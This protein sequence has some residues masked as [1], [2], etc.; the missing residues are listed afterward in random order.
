MAAKHLSL[1]SCVRKSGSEGRDGSVM[2]SGTFNGWATSGTRMSLGTHQAHGATYASWGG[3]G[4]GANAPAPTTPWELRGN[5]QLV[6]DV[7]PARW[8]P[9]FCL[10]VVQRYLGIS[11]LVFPAGAGG[12]GKTSE[13]KTSETIFL[14]F[15]CFC[16][17]PGSPQSCGNTWPNLNGLYF[18]AAASLTDNIQEA[19]TTCAR[20][21]SPACACVL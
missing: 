2:S 19:D 11:C 15:H 12:L 6:S 16:F 4:A 20:C 5:T 7:L 8:F 21:K 10:S 1:K 13:S 3:A 14:I 17:P 18:H 9:T